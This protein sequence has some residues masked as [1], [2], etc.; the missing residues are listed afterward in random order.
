MAFQHAAI[1]VVQIVNPV[2]ILHTVNAVSGDDMVTR[3]STG[4]PITA[5]CVQTPRFAR[6]VE[7]VTLVSYVP[8]N[9]PFTVC[10]V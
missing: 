3:V 4:V 8:L 2:L 7:L 9:A 1:H 10:P 5:M 6:A